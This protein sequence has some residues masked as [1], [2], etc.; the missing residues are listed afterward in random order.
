MHIFVILANIIILVLC[1]LIRT[2]FYVVLQ[3]T[4]CKNHS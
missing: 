3:I 4:M 1:K 2:C